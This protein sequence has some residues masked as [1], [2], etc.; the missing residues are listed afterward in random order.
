MLPNPMLQG[1]DAQPSPEEIK[2]KIQKF[3]VESNQAK[4]ASLQSKSS[5]ED[6]RVQAMQQAFEVL[7]D[8]GVNPADPSSLA[9]FMQ[10]LET[11]DPDAAEMMQNAL[12]AIFGGEEAPAPGSV[13]PEA[14]PSPSDMMPG[15]P[16]GPSLMPPG[17]GQPEQPAIQ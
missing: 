5:I 8:A 13:P 4:T 9:A 2:N 12:S 14:A 3:M 11:I 7:K 1:T 16:G 10:K 15:M 17:L 6:A